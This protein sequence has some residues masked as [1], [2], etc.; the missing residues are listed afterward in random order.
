MTQMAAAWVVDGVVDEIDCPAER[1]APRCFARGAFLVAA[2]APAEAVYVVRSGQVRVFLLDEAGHETTTALLGAGALVGTDALLARPV[3][4]A[5]AEAR[6]PVAAWAISASR[7]RGQL[8]QDPAL[9]RILA[10]G[11]GR[12]L[13]LAEGLLRDVALLPV[14]ER[15]PSVLER[16]RAAFGGERPQLSGELLAAVAA[17]RPETV[18]R[19]RRASRLATASVAD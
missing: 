8:T 10:E 5:F 19:V 6:T 11:L 13:A 15:L 2:G 4:H 7:L 16:V 1:G 18:S 17:T 3:Y 12:R 9:L 14:G